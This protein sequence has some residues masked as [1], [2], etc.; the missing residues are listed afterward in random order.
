MKRRILL[1]PAGLHGQHVLPQNFPAIRK[2]DAVIL[3]LFGVPARANTQQQTAVGEKIQGRSLFGHENG[4][5]FRNQG[6]T[7]ANLEVIGD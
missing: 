2:G 5:A 3:E 7:G 1:C 4:I 6:N